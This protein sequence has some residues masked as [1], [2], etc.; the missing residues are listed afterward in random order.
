MALRED[1]RGFAALPPEYEQNCET[2]AAWKRDYPVVIKNAFL[3][4]DPTLN[5]SF[6]IEEPI[7]TKLME[8]LSDFDASP[9]FGAH[10]EIALH[11]VA[12][13]KDGTLTEIAR[14]ERT[15]YFDQK[16]REWKVFRTN[17]SLHPILSGKGFGAKILHAEE[18]FFRKI[19]IREIRLRAGETVGLYNN[20]RQGF[21][22]YDPRVAL[23]ANAD[24]RH[25]VKDQPE[26]KAIRYCDRNGTMLDVPVSDLESLPPFTAPEIASAEALD[27]SGK[28]LKCSTWRMKGV[29]DSKVYRAALFK[30]FPIP[31]L[32]GLRLYLFLPEQLM[33]AVRSVRKFST[34]PEAWQSFYETIEKMLKLVHQEEVLAAFQN[35]TLQEAYVELVRTLDLRAIASEVH[36][37]FGKA[38]FLNAASPH[39]RDYWFGVKRLTP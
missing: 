29:S 3:A 16:T 34:W 18:D 32:P 24:F 12:R 13:Q 33:A 6:T 21:D 28:A 2:L 1:D 9:S 5:L 36:W 39:Y 20:A 19:G 22:F 37:G 38:F 14:F 10:A 8:K 17:M 30:N 11:V 25:S 27:A 7:D 26:I 4:C 35:P 23:Q 31:L 15:F